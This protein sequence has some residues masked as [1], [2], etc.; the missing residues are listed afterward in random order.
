MHHTDQT[1]LVVMDATNGRN[2]SYTRKGVTVLTVKVPRTISPRTSLVECPFF[3]GN[4][5]CTVLLKG[6]T[7]YNQEQAACII[8]DRNGEGSITQACPL[9]ESGTIKVTMKKGKVQI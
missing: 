4:N 6:K 9:K 5:R 8:R 2:A 1:V 7:A 3:Q